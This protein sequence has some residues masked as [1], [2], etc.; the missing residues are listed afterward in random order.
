MKAVAD[1]ITGMST[2]D[3]S[4]V[5]SNGVINLH[6]FEIG[7]GDIEVITE[8]MPGYLTASEGGLTIALDN[9]LSPELIR[10]GMA[11]E[12][13]NRVQN[14]RK[15]LGFDV[16]D[17]IH[18]SIQENTNEWKDSLTE[19]KGYISQEVQALSID[20]VNEISEGYSEVSIDDIH[21]N[22]RLTVA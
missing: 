21:L 22:V 18:I 1:L 16:I 14:L 11:R 7:M 4:T 13:V 10:E 15:D 6:G 8:D 12:F 3:L 2:N 9:T 19:F 17:K 20:W 5:E